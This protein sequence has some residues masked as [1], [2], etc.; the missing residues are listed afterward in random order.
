MTRINSVAAG[1]SGEAGEKAVTDSKAKKPVDPVHNPNQPWVCTQAGYLFFRLYHL[2]YERLTRCRKQCNEKTG[3]VDQ[4]CEGAISAE[5]GRSGLYRSFLG[6]LLGLLDTSLDNARYE[7]QC[8]ELLGRDAFHLFT[9]DKLVHQLLKH[10]GTLMAEETCC[11]LQGLY[12]KEE[13]QQDVSAAISSSA[14]AVL[15]FVIYVCCDQPFLQPHLFLFWHPQKVTRD[16]EVGLETSVGVALGGEEAYRLQ[17]CKGLKVD[18]TDPTLCV[19][20]KLEDCSP[21]KPRQAP[22]IAGSEASS[23]DVMV[24]EPTSAVW[25]VEP[26][27]SLEFLGTLPFTGN[28][29]EEADGKEGDEAMAEASEEAADGKAED[30][31]A[32]KRRKT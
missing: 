9:L 2:L 1:E 6:L 12:E 3:G 26:C 30:G 20:T 10:M 17:Y 25:K 5:V 22:T 8:R 18:G 16:L 19:G 28:D 27:M 32:A 23:S 4:E 24:V 29:D 11:E 13:L 31:P 15:Q 21:D 14:F 7:D